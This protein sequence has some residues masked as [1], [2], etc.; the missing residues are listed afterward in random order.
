MTPNMRISGS[1]PVFED[2]ELVLGLV[3]PVGTNFRKFHN[4]LARCLRRHGYVANPLG[5]NSA[6]GSIDRIGTRTNAAE[7]LLGAR[8]GGGERASE[9]RNLAGGLMK[10][11]T[12]NMS[13]DASKVF[14]ET[15]QKHAMELEG[16]PDWKRAGINVAQERRAPRPPVVISSAETQPSD[17]RGSSED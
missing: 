11:I 14:W 15:A 1:N 4:L 5:L 12:R 17:Q 6:L 10:K 9:R 7:L 8:T 2:S 16:W 13:T 3:A